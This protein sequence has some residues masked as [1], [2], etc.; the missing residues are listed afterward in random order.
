MTTVKRGFKASDAEIGA[1]AALSGDT[2]PLHVDG[3]YAEDGY[4]GERVV[5]GVFVL[6]W[7]SGCLADLPVEGDVI[8]T[9]LEDVSFYNP[10]AAGE[11]VEVEVEHNGTAVAEFTVTGTDGEEKVEGVAGVYVTDPEEDDG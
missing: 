6:S 5:H 9:K 8:L 2:N 3:N 10:V 1:F 11:V 7:V 4:F